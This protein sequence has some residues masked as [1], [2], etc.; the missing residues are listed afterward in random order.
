[1][2][3]SIGIHL[4]NLLTI[5]ALA[6]ISYFRRYKPT[7]AGVFGTL[8]IGG[9]FLLFVQYGIIPGLVEGAAQFEWMFTNWFGLPFLSGSIF[10]WLSCCCFI[11][12]GLRLTSQ[13]KAPMGIYLAAAGI[14]YLVFFASIWAAIIGTRHFPCLLG[15][16]PKTNSFAFLLAVT[17]ILPGLILWFGI[18]KDKENDQVRG[19]G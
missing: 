6:F 9:F 2:G 11:T 4:L 13:N 10:T 16:S 3:L 17:G 18:Y 1:M 15:P 8:F 5:P 7:V 12:F 14:F 19:Q